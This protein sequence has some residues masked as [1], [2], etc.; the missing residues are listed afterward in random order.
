MRS[1]CLLTGV[2]TLLT[3]PIFARAAEAERGAAV[4]WVTY[5]AEDAKSNGSILG[6]DYKGQTA[7]RE[8]S[9][10][11]CVRLDSAGHFIEIVAK[12]DAQGLV[13][14]YSIPDSTDGR[15][16]DATLGLY[17]N[18]RLHKKLSMTSKYSHLY[19]AYPFSNDPSAGTPRNFWDELRVLP[20]TIRSGDVIRLQK[21]A[22]DAAAEYLI[23]LIDLER[24]PDASAKPK[25]ALSVT[26]FGATSDDEIDDRPA[27]VAA[28]AAAKEAKK[29][30]WIPPGRFVM[31]GA[32]DVSDVAIAGAGMWHS[33]VV[34][35]DDYVPDNRV[36][37]YG[38]GSNV[39]LAD[40]AIVGKLNYRND[41]E[42]N[43]GIGESFGTG[44]T[45]KNIWV[46]HTK[47]GA[48]L[49]NA[50]GLLV[51]GCRFRN[52]IADGINLCVGMRN[53]TVRN[54][55]ARGT[56]DDAF[57]MWPATYTKAAYNH[58][59]NRFVNCTAQLPFL[60]QGFSIYGGEDNSVEDCLAID[61]PYGCGL[62]ASTTFPT[63]VGFGG[64]TS[65]LRNQIIRAGD[66][67][68]AIGIVANLIPLSGLR[69][70][71]IAITDSPNDA[72][73]FM[74]IKGRALS[75]T[76]FDRV[77]IRNAGIG[78]AGYGVVS[79]DDAVGSATLRHLTVENAKS[80]AV[81]NGSSTFDVTLGEGTS[82]LQKMS[83]GPATD[84]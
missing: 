45:I 7:A 31:K 26:D 74:S 33:T 32:I 15:G 8:A 37:F 38:R 47:A 80:G 40:F 78:G 27:F 72:I 35:V 84:P 75:A 57:A 60:A 4:P 62:F 67:E 22:D 28:I 66:R 34:G 44:S 19:G 36:A 71:D 6:P 25:D 10:R 49:V 58:G 61:I 17:V 70:E 2:L 82:A 64:T 79:A 9:H 20:G 68:G 39:H 52:N 83:K 21:D 81:R 41:G 1:L 56:G 76:T 24:V 3:L 59:S 48:W 51:E 29:S 18:G 42:P 13:V 43:D 14:R 63:E 11:R 53:T 77:Q 73:R 23:D 69:F 46:E 65:Y 54:C 30:V 50:D 5:E 12:A 55:T 16:T